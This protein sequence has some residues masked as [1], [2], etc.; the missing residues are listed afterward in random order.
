MS[1]R[2]FTFL[3]LG[4]ALIAVLGCQPAAEPPEPVEPTGP[5]A[6]EDRQAIDALRQRETEN[7]SAG[8]VDI[9]LQ[10]FTDDAVLMPPGEP[11]VVGTAAQRDWLDAFYEQFTVGVSYHE[12]ELELAGDWAFEQL[13]FTMTLTPVEGGEATTMRGRGLHVYERQA[14]GSWRIA[15]DVWNSTEPAGM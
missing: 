15:Y 8:N 1:L 9:I 6:A 13:S 14:D 11:A 12:T 7:F 2:K 4:A 10:L 5:T 3:L